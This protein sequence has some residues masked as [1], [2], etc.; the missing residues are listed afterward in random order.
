MFEY[1]ISIKNNSIDVNFFDR[2]IA[3]RSFNTALLNEL[4]SSI[5]ENEIRIQD[6]QDPYLIAL[7]AAYAYLQDH[8]ELLI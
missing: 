6:E 4:G 1:V 3:D 7:K 8:P 5:I 2:K